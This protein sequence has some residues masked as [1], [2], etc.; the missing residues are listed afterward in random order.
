M[1]QP[2]RHAEHSIY[3]NVAE[4]LLE[5]I[6]STASESQQKPAHKIFHSYNQF[7]DETLVVLAVALSHM[8]GTTK[9]RFHQFR[10]CVI[11]PQIKNE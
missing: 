3:N 8:M 11:V 1:P 10:V 9:T 6:H 4:N 7:I 2:K 5:P